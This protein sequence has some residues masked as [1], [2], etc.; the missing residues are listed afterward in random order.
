MT[1]G[2]SGPNSV[3]T[4]R[5]PTPTFQPDPEGPDVLAKISR[6]DAMSNVPPTSPRRDIRSAEVP[7][8]P[9]G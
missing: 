4:P 6:A 2:P 9:K 8:T 5:S 7:A 1:S 3:Q